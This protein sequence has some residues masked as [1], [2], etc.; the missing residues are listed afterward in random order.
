MKNLGKQ[1]NKKNGGITLIALVITIIVL[2]ILASVTIATLTGKNGIIQKATQASKETEIEQAKEQAKLDISN[3]IAEKLKNGEDAK[4]NNSIIKNILDGKDYVKGEPLE[5]SFITK[6]GE[7]EIFYSE[8]YDVQN[9]QI[10][11][12]VKKAKEDGTVFSKN[13]TLKDE[14]GNIIT[15]PAGFKIAEDSEINVTEGIVIEDGS[16]TVTKESQFVWIPV[17][18]IYTN[19]EQT[20]TKNIE[21]KRYVFKQDG[22]IDEDLSKENPTDELITI[23]NESRYFIENLTDS[24]ESDRQYAKDIQEFKVSAETNNGYYIG[25]YEARTET[26]RTN[27]TDSLTPVTVKSGTEDERAYVYNYVTQ[28][29]AANL[30]KEM[31]NSQE[32]TSDLINSFAWDTAILFLQTFDNRE[33]K[34]ELNPYSRQ[35]SLNSVLAEQGTNHL[36]DVTQ[37]DKICNVWDMAS[38]CYEW[39]TETCS[40]NDNPCVRRGGFFYNTT[41]TYSGIRSIGNTMDSTSSYSFRPIIY[42]NT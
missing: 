14:Y 22:S 37:R 23:Q 12:T 24:E 29:Q 5:S 7:Y 18:L 21:M 1:K 39:S 33:N 4:I 26:K 32:Y 25:R 20:G 27:K 9:E 40:Q 10:E 13:T 15:I 28:L 11:E 34:E 17:G 3:Y 35:T 31:Y 19:A 36:E 30:S 42:L 38:N 6:Q 2:L 8:L 41:K 16:E